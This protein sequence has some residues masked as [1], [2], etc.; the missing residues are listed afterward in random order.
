MPA[1]LAVKFSAL[2]MPVYYLPGPL[3]NP[4]ADD[5]VVVRRDEEQ[6]IGFVA[7]VEYRATEHL[8][9]RP[10]PYP[11]VLRR[12]TP[13]EVESYWER[14]AVEKRAMALA[15][16]RA[17]AHGL[18]MKFSAARYLAQSQ[19]VLY[20]F[21]ADQRVDFRLLVRDLSMML[22]SRVELWQVGARDEAKM[23]DGYGVC[24]ERTCCSS[25]MQDFHPVNARMAR[26]Q[27]LQVPP[28]KLMGQCG[29]FLCCLSYEVDQYREMSKGAIPKGATITHNGKRGVVVDRNLIRRSYLVRTEDGA[30]ATILADEMEGAEVQ[31][32]EQMA[33]FGAKFAPRLKE[34]KPADPPPPEEEPKTDRPGRRPRPPKGRIERAADDTPPPSLPEAPPP[35]RRA[36]LAKAPPP[37]PKA[38]PPDAD[39]PL[40]QDPPEGPGKRRR[41]RRPKAKPP[42]PEARAD[43][44]DPP[45]DAPPQEGGKKEKGRGGRRRKRRR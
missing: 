21:T 27:E 23:L 9:R 20:H 22:R 8:D 10:A 18:A 15:R 24:G 16:D 31:V 5:F 34:A 36:R 41:L 45:E 17:E 19:R 1:L 7:T 12:A 37:L 28:V 13:E 32:P 38:P 40:E 35:P 6:D 30:L 26:D 25:Y 4:R 39:I 2:D 43:A 14:R 29:R 42:R 33:K 3:D 11:A 44:G